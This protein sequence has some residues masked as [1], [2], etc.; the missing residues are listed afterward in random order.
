[1]THKIKININTDE[2]SI[3]AIMNNDFN[4]IFVADETTVDAMELYEKII[5]FIE[6]EIGGI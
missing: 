1:M 6:K 4:T 3:I 2:K 5:D